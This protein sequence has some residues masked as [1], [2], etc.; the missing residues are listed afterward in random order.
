MAETYSRLAGKI[1]NTVVGTAQTLYEVGSG[2][3]T[4][5]TSAVV[6][7]IV[8]CNTGTTTANFSLA[9]SKTTSFS[10]SGDAATG[11]GGYLVYQAAIAPNDTTI[12]SLGI[13][14]DS[15]NKYLLYSSS[16]NTVTFNAF[17]AEIS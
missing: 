6:S 10:T 12:F 4:A 11:I 13:T 3:N 15:I 5:A 1:G 2:Q 9:V 8:V 16:A 17:G 14:L 7:S